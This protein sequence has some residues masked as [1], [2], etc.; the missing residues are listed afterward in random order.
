MRHLHWYIFDSAPSNLVDDVGV[1]FG[2]V[3]F[4]SLSI[5]FS[6]SG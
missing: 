3:H 1:H 2:P 6:S 5:L 4:F